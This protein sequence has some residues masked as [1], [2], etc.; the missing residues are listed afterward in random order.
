VSDEIRQIET[1]AAPAAIGAYSQACVHGGLV[2]C[3]GQIALDAASGEM[4]GETAAEQA[5]RAL[6]NLSAVL[7]AAG[8][9]FSRMLKVTIFLASMEDF[10]A[11]NEVYRAALGEARP[12]RACVE[13]SRLPK[14][15]LVEIDCV[16]VVD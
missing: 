11:V 4:V 9:D 12:A 16:A 1:A 8:S 2:Y 10:A 6:S 5:E 7:A 15:A 3:S 13:A 14:D